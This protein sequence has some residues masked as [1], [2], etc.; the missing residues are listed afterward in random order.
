MEKKDLFLPSSECFPLNFHVDFFFSM[1]NA[2]SDS[3]Y[4]AGIFVHV[5][6]DIT[7]SLAA[8]SQDMD[9]FLRHSHCNIERKKWKKSKDWEVVGGRYKLTDD[10]YGP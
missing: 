10:L 3:C 1:S 5:H 9:S 2:H 6:A 4:V 7:T 8:A